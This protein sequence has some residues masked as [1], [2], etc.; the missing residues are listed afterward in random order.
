MEEVRA[1]MG[2][3]WVMRVSRVSKICLEGLVS[4]GDLIGFVTNVLGIVGL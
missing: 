1:E 4:L 2:K 3:G